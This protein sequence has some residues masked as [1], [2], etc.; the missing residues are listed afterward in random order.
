[1]R[2]QVRT[3]FMQASVVGGRCAVGGRSAVGGAGFPARESSPVTIA[4]PGHGPAGWKACPTNGRLGR[5][6]R[7]LLGS[8]LVALLLSLATVACAQDYRFSVPKM[9]LNVYPE[10]D[11]SVTLE[12]DVD[13]TCSP[14]AHAIDIIDMGL[15]HGGYNISSMSAAINGERLSDIRRSEVVNPGVEV[16]L[17]EGAIEQGQSGHFWFRCIMPKLVYQDTTRQD[18]ASLQITPTWWDG[19]YLEGTTD[20]AIVV[21]LSQDL[22]PDD[23]L[24]QGKPF[25]AKAMTKSHL[26]VAW[27]L[28]GVRVDGP[29]KVGVSFPKGSM[30]VVRMTRF[31][32]LMKWWQEAHSLR[33]LWG[34]ALLVLTGIMFFRA[35]AGTG[36]SCFLGI[37]VI[38]IGVFVVSPVIHFF[39][40][41]GLLLIWHFSEKSLKRRRGK[42]LPAIAS[43]EG[44]GIKRGLTAPEAAIL[45]ELPL[46]KVLSLVVFG[47][48]KKRIVEQVSAQ[49]L[50][51][52][53]NPQYDSDS[54]GERRTAAATAGT[55]IHGYE[56]P[57]IDVIRQ[58]GAI[59][60]EKMSFGRPMEQ[61]IKATAE[62]VAGF[63]VEKTKS[64][65][66]HIVN[67]AWV[68]AEKLGDI[69][70]RTTYADENLL[71]LLAAPDYGDRFDRWHTRRHYYDPP[72]YRTAGPIGGGGVSVP[73]TPVG[74]RTSF[75]DVAASFSGWTEN[76]S[77]GLASSLD[78]VKLE[79]A[80]SGIMDLSGVDK[81]TSD[82]LKSMSEGSGGGGGGG[83]CACAGCACA[84]ACAGGGR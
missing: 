55:V 28:R 73:E 16:H 20:L 77:S 11:G 60:L 48:L 6:A 62:R 68:E 38:L 51:V 84:C 25:D 52:R 78:G 67:Q 49:P 71:W 44:G 18:Y 79:T 33:F 59:P 57:F 74:G 82:T 13:L 75:G 81:M 30:N 83:G 50:T 61:L 47:L 37:L 63:D 36:W 53:I 29:H 3:G 42:Y 26:A 41:P 21:N 43:V 5:S 66:R 56:Q 34:I 39:A 64:Y 7:G 69:Q 15:P 17:G 35:S 27:D 45:L 31:G 14:G 12:Y 70:E 24:H 40:L 1:M 80:K 2:G 8:L 72:W 4:R 65:Y 19:Q 9:T 58:R 23:V 10:Q 76:V 46:S 32:L 54:R 22:N